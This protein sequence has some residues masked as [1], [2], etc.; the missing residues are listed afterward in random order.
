VPDAR[1][2][3]VGFFRALEAYDLLLASSIRSGTALDMAAA[4]YARMHPWKGARRAR[5]M[6]TS[7][8]MGHCLAAAG[9]ISG[10]RVPFSHMCC[11]CAVALP[12]DCAPPT[13]VLV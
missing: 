10:A 12:R 9:L 2:Q 3:V 4:R 5:L 6:H 1:A 7:T 8:S 11:E 13:Y